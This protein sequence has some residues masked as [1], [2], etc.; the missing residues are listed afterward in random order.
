[1]Q[2]VLAHFE[3]VGQSHRAGEAGIRTVDDNAAAFP[4]RQEAR[5]LGRRGAVDYGPGRTRLASVIMAR[6]TRHSAKPVEQYHHLDTLV[7][8]V[9]EVQSRWD[10]WYRLRIQPYRTLDNSIEGAV[11]SFIDATEA[12]LHREALQKAE[13]LAKLVRLAC[14]ARDAITAHDLQGQTL[15]WSPGAQ[16]LYGWSAAE[17]LQLNVL[18]RIP[19]AL[20]EGAL[21]TLAQLGQTPDFAPCHTQRLTSTGAIL[22]VSLIAGTLLDAAG[23]VYAITTTERAISASV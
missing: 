22:N 10:I 8:K 18:A 20:R 17:A 9:L 15:S 23:K 5:L 14:D 3:C 13:E 7:P 6:R 1:M 19:P 16:R 11:I 21:S 2:G 12:V 4:I